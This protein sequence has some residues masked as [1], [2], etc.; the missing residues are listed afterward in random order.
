MT[1]AGEMDARIAA[2]FT[3]GATSDDVGRLLAEVEAAANAA[4]AVAKEA[5]TRA[6][7]PLL[8]CDA[9]TVARREMDDAEFTRDRLTEA[10]RR[11]GERVAELRAFE[12]ASAQRAAHERISAERDRLA[13]E[14]ER[15][16][17]PIAEVAGLVA[18]IDACNREI[19]N[20][21]AALGSALA[22]SPAVGSGAGNCDPVGGLRGLGRI[23][24]GC[25][26]A[27]PAGHK[28]K[29][30]R[31]LKVLPCGRHRSVPFTNPATRP[32]VVRFA[33][34]GATW[35]LKQVPCRRMRRCPM[36]LSLG[37]AAGAILG[38]RQGRL[39]RQALEAQG[40]P[41]PLTPI[42]SGKAASGHPRASERPFVASEYKGCSEI[43]G[44]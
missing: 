15:M 6:L 40:P 44:V 19:R 36:W 17:K 28:E 3:D 30:E 13:A 8:P 38:H 20:I 31:T 39:L 33:S 37:E 29:G 16:A 7:D 5:R 32:M 43:R 1:S 35:Q 22:L 25:E 9:V 12:K 23:P 24:S 18:Q 42:G 14:L 27:I 11:L 26:A 21:N 34:F 4:D 2:A 10:A 41:A